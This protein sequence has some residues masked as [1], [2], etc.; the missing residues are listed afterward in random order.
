MPKKK[1]EKDFYYFWAEGQDI[2]Q[3]LLNKWREDPNRQ[4]H[5]VFCGNHYSQG[6]L[7]GDFIYCRG[8]REYKGMEPCLPN[9]EGLCQLDA[10]WTPSNCKGGKL[11][12]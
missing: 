1:E 11:S 9:E 6:D 8:C 5:C 4:Y 7:E 3:E 12:Q 10:G 2:P